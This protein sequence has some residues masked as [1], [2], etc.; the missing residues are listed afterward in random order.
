MDRNHPR[1]RL[2]VPGPG[3]PR[4]KH[5]CSE[6]IGVKDSGSQ[7]G[8]FHLQAQAGL[9][10]PFLSFPAQ[11]DMPDF[12]CGIVLTFRQYVRAGV[13]GISLKSWLRWSSLI[14]GRQF[15]EGLADRI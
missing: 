4:I 9:H 5:T 10:P 3:V 1:F 8:A 2:Q 14:A 7:L 11:K 12:I 15:Q 13:R 6:W